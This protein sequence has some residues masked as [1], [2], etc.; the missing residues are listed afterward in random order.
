FVLLDFKRVH[1]LDAAVLRLLEA[2]ANA[3]A[4]QDRRLLLCR[5]RRELLPA[6]FGAELDPHAAAA[7][8]F[9]PQLDLGLEACEN[10][11]LQLHGLQ[12]R[13]AD[14][15]LPLHEHQLCEGLSAA[16]LSALQ[17]WLE[18]RRFEPG[19]LILGQ[20]EPADG[21]YLL[22]RGEVSVSVAL[23]DGGRKRLSTLQ[24]GMS[25]GELGLLGGERSADVRADSMVDGLLLSSAAWAALERE[26]PAL[27]LRLMHRLLQ[28]MSQ[29]TLR[30]SA[31]V[32][33]LEA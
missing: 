25:F 26:Q 17:A 20:G 2:L 10:A 30:L 5:V 18:P 13:A 12:H 9:Q 24:A 33:A 11:L 23:P 31:E 4:A 8:S 19:A 27:L 15:A 7:L 29:T 28:S 1:R 22:M 32:A 16:E 6:G 21:L 3:C 14:R